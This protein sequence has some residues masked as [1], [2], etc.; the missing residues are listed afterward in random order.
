M[1]KTDKNDKIKKN[2]KDDKEKK[3]DE[4]KDEKKV[5]KKVTK[6]IKKSNISPQKY[7]LN[8]LADLFGVS[9][10]TMRSMYKIRGIDKKEKFSYDEAFEKFSNIV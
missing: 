8:E 7:T 5:E 1:A 6:K 2:S 9:V 4:K 10:M 3:Q